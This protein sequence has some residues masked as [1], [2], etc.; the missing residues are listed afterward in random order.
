[1]KRHGLPAAL[2]WLCT[3]ALLAAG[4]SSSGGRE[5]H[6][7]GDSAPPSPASP[8]ASRPAS[9]LPD[10]TGR[11]AGGVNRDDV[12]GDGHADAVVNGWYRQPKNSGKWRNNRFIA[13]ASPGGPD[14]AEAFRLSERFVAPDPK[15]VDA[16]FS[17]DSSVQFTGD[18]DDDG[19]A[20]IVVRAPRTD[21]RGRLTDHQ[22]VVWGGPKGPVGTTEL[23]PG[24]HEAAAVGDFDGDGALD[25]LTLAPASSEYDLKPQP[26]KVLHGPLDRDGGTPRTTTES[27]VGHGGWVPVSHVLAGDFDGDG[28]DDLLTV[29]EYGEEDV[30]FEEEGIEDVEDAYLYRGTPR[31]LREAGTV[32]GITGRL[33]GYAAIPHA[34]GDFDGD[35]RD[36]VLA[37]PSE[38]GGLIVVPGDAK[39]L[40]RGR[41]PVALERVGASYVRAPAVGDLNGDGRDDVAFRTPG[42]DRRIGRV[43]V[44]LGGPGGLDDGRAAVIDRYAIG[45]DGRPAHSGDRDFF[46][47]DLHI[48][49]LD[50]DG[51]AELLIGTFGFNEPRKDAG[52]WILSGTESG[53]STTDRRF[54][55]TK[56][57][58]G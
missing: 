12:N 21:G 3:A 57:F 54:V 49:D 7:S 28:R 39:G 43:T 17:L 14:P 35:G 34:V 5:G 44:L 27:D 48:A 53:P 31:G 46:G 6:A 52:Y 50:T 19:N 58:G 18:L 16:P 1:M 4:C 2:V 29:A 40:G 36:D 10:P 26:A 23:P 38:Q 41:G 15:V 33:T 37:R 42:K 13:L 30:R 25:L 55:P 32:P 47:L 8:P 56:D 11:D 22:Y 20:D 45:L 9:P 51:R 24:T